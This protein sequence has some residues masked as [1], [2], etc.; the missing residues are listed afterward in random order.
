MLGP[1][2]RAY[3]KTPIIYG[4]DFV[5]DKLLTSEIAQ[6]FGLWRVKIGLASQEP[7]SPW[8]LWQYTENAKIQGIAAPVDMN[9]LASDQTLEQLQER[10]LYECTLLPN[11]G[12][13]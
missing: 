3:R 8:I 5:L 9:V 4:T 2:Q 13:L 7:A 11:G 10:C 1:I 12:R 6:K